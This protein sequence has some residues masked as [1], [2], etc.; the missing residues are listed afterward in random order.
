MVWR[1][2][3]SI[4]I[5]PG[6]VLVTVPA[7][8]LWLTPMWSWPT[9]SAPSTWI[10]L[11]LG[12]PAIALA[13]WTVRLFTT[14][15]RGTPAPWDPPQ[16][17]VVKGPYRHV[18]NP[19]ISSVLIMLTALSVLFQSC[20]LLGWLGVFFLLNSLYFPLFEEKDL[21]ARFTDDYRAY[22]ANVPRWLPRLTPW[23]PPER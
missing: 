10:A 18:R 4:L 7:I 12:L 21:D 14:A 19:M 13:A 5:L 3:K 6:T 8:L 22:K 16:R 15:G 23:S 1:I 11:V 9:W 2:L 17:L 20:A